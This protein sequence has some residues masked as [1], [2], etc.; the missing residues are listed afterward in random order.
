MLI[1]LKLYLYIFEAVRAHNAQ[2][3]LKQSKQAIKL[4]YLYSRSG[5]NRARY[6]ARI[7]LCT[8]LLIYSAN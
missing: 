4:K 1:N 5:L 2:I 3:Q 8:I 6:F 7:H